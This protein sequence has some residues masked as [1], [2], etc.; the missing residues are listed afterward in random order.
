MA[1]LNDEK[2]HPAHPDPH[3]RR[4]QHPARRGRRRAAQAGRLTGSKRRAGVIRPTT[5]HTWKGT[6]VN[7]SWRLP[8]PFSHGAA[9]SPPRPQHPCLP[10]SLSV[11]HSIPLEPRRA[12]LL[13]AEAVRWEEEGVDQGLQ[14]SSWAVCDGQVRIMNRVRVRGLLTKGASPGAASLQAC[15]DMLQLQLPAAVLGAAHKHHRDDCEQNLAPRGGGHPEGT[16]HS[17]TASSRVCSGSLAHGWVAPV[18]KLRPASPVSAARPPAL[19]RSAR[20]AP[21]VRARQ[22]PGVA[23]ALAPT[24]R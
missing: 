18:T 7:L 4:Q 5:A 24:A 14:F 9:P 2:T 19:A 1:R 21:R 15:R 12:A 22:Q 23:P 10:R 16:L 3:L 11:A 6:E 20:G 17:V 8:H 13:R